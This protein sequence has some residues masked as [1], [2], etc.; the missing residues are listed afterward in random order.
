MQDGRSLYKVQVYSRR[1]QGVPSLADSSYLCYTCS[2]EET[3]NPDAKGTHFLNVKLI[4]IEWLATLEHKPEILTHHNFTSNQSLKVWCLLDFVM[5]L[6][7]ALQNT[8]LEGY[9]EL[10]CE[11]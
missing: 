1:S 5:V 3:L 9:A 8:I 4:S 7:M 11:Q 2:R 10:H 6:L